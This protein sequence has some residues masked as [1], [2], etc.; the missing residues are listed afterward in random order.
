MDSWN[1]RSSSYIIPDEPF[2]PDFVDDISDDDDYEEILLDEPSLTN[3]SSQHHHS[4]S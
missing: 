1:A 2:I 4:F 3:C